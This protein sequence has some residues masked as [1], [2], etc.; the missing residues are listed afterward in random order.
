MEE[1]FEDVLLGDGTPCSAAGAAG[2]PSPQPS[3]NPFALQNL[4]QLDTQAPVQL[5]GRSRLSHVADANGEYRGLLLPSTRTH[6]LPC[7]LWSL[8]GSWQPCG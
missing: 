8:H 3:G 5:H 2:P 7:R 4:K 1:G 6:N